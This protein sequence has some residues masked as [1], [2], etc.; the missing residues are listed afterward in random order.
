MKKT[1][2][3]IGILIGLSITFFVIFTTANHDLSKEEALTI[4][5]EKYL[6]FLWMVDGAFNNERMNGEFIVNG[7]MLSNDNKKFTCTYSKKNNESCTGNN[8]EEAFHSLFS[9]NLSY[10]KVYSDGIIYTWYKYEKGKYVFTNIKNCSVKRMSLDQEIKLT[11]IKDDE[12][13]FSVKEVDSN[14]IR[15]FVLVKENDNWKVSKAFYKDLCE[16]VYIIK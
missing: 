15:E 11:S 16:I 12:L 14:L 7:K 9:S 4:G 1:L 10:D 6:E 3:F 8:F 5:E 2:L 13:V